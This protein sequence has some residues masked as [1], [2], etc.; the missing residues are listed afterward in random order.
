[1]AKYKIELKKSAVKEIKNL[2]NDIIKR[3]IIKLDELAINPSG[4]GSLKL[5][6]EDKF[7]VR[8]GNYRILYQI[9][10]AKLVVII[11]KVAHIKSSYTQ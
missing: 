1:M 6:N 8:I 4:K 11:V 9:F 7:R 5:T 10:D 2:P 3:V